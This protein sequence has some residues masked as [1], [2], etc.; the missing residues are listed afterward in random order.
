MDVGNNNTV[1]AV[2]GGPRTENLKNV[3]K[4]Q[5]VDLSDWTKCPVQN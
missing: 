1:N 2:S 5:L 4:D 3:F